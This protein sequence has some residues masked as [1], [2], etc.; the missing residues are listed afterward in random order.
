M[1]MQKNRVRF[2]PLIFICSSLGVSICILPLLLNKS[3]YCLF[4]N[5]KFHYL[6]SISMSHSRFKGRSMNN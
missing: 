2:P 5:L 4:L 6:F 1:E 3:L